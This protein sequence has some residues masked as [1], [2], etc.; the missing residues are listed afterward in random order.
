MS[1]G[2]ICCHY[3]SFLLPCPSSVQL[4]FR[5]PQSICRL[6]SLRSRKYSLARWTLCTNTCCSARILP[7]HESCQTKWPNPA[8][9]FCFLLWSITPGE[10]G[11]SMSLNSRGVGVG[12][13]AGPRAGITY[14]ERER[15][16]QSI[17]THAIITLYDY[18]KSLNRIYLSYMLSNLKQWFPLLHSHSI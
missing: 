7:F 4:A 13:L 9:C 18:V 12:G 16:R 14:L 10:G 3:L 5:T 2:K 8:S 11:W 15:E 6:R 1:M 17:K